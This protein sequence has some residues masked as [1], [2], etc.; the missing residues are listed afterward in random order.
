MSRRAST[1]FLLLALMTGCAGERLGAPCESSEDCDGADRCT[2]GACVPTEDG[3]RG[4]DAGPGPA[5]CEDGV[6]DLSAFG[7]AC[8]R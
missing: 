1:A 5:S 7:E 6:W 4:R 2:D 8:F 3:G